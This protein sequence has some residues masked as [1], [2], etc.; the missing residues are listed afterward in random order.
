M[1]PVASEQ[2][3]RSWATATAARRSSSSWPGV[4]AGCGC[5]LLA[6]A[7]LISRARRATAALAVGRSTGVRSCGWPQPMAA[8]PVGLF[9][10]RQPRVARYPLEVQLVA[11]AGDAV[12]Q[13]ANAACQG[14][15]GVVRASDRRD[16]GLG[17]AAQKESFWRRLHGGCGQCFVD[18]REF[19]PGAAA[20]S[21]GRHGDLGGAEVLVADEQRSASP[22]A[23]SARG[24]AVR[25][26]GDV[27]RG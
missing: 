4:G 24:R 16:G 21:A 18:G 15:L 17:V 23:R 1:S 25:P 12:R 8:R 10:F 27:W 22:V 5:L 26:D 3:T 9:I 6:R 11:R 13:V 7:S 2:P 20:H 14:R 19:R